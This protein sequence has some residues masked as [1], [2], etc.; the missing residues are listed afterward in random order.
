MRGLQLW[1]QS[2]VPPVSIQSEPLSVVLNPAIWAVY[3]WKRYKAALL[4]T[5]EFPHVNE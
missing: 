4:K 3:K 2:H 1:M 5:K